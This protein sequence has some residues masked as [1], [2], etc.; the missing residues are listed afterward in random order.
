MNVDFLKGGSRDEK[1]RMVAEI[2]YIYA[3]TNY[4]SLGV[5]GRGGDALSVRL[6]AKADG[7]NDE[8]GTGGNGRA[9]EDDEETVDSFI[10]NNQQPR[11]WSRGQGRGCPLR[12]PRR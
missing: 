1:K 3:T 9:K 4:H 8:G 2:K 10:C 12:L 11:P 6:S 7:L 5:E